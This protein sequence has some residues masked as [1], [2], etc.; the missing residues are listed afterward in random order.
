MKKYTAK[1][2]VAAPGE[3]NL[4]IAHARG[5][6]RVTLSTKIGVNV[7]YPNQ[8]R[9]E[10]LRAEKNEE[11]KYPS[12]SSSLFHPYLLFFIRT[13]SVSSLE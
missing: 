8:S 13:F 11:K 12:F 1:R 2:Q 3:T 10:K 4:K 7:S 6:H 5:A 9:S